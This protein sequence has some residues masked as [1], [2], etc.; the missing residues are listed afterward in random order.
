MQTLREE[1]SATDV[2]V[3]AAILALS[4][5]DLRKLG[6]A[7][8]F[9]IA[10]LGRKALGRQ[11]SDLLQEA[12]S[13]TVAGDRRWNK[14][15]V[16]FVGHLLGA[17]KSIASHWREQ[18]RE[19][20]PHLEADLKPRNPAIDGETP[21]DHARSTSPN[22]E[23]ILIEKQ[24]IEQIDALF[25]DDNSGLKVSQAL[26]TGTKPERIRAELH[27]EITEYETTVRRVRRRIAAFLA[28]T[29]AHG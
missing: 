27:M 20:E 13:R 6:A 7:A 24:L 22:P 28:R 16:D 5:S 12:V 2:E 19:A 18:F 17:M 14:G 10:G 15:A 26:R 8:E 1:Q 11:S 29:K 23:E 25:A 9:R 3:E 4:H 21:L